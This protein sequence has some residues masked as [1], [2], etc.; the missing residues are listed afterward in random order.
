MIMPNLYVRTMFK[1]ILDIDECALKIDGCE[2]DCIN[3]NGSFICTC[4]EF[5]P[6]F[7]ANGTL[8]VGEY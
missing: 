6:G 1:S 8:C 3:T 7:K 4:P 5:G 2:D